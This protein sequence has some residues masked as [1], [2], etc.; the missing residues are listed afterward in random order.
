MPSERQRNHQKL[1]FYG[2]LHFTVN[3]FTDRGVGDGTESPSIFCPERFDADQW[4]N[5]LASSGMKVRFSPVSITMASASGPVN[6]RIIQ[7]YQ[8]LSVVER[9]MWCGRYRRLSGTRVKV[10]YLLVALGPP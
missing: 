7:W 8:V 9:A 1:E 5:A 4:A 2:F 10:W 6:I 3:T